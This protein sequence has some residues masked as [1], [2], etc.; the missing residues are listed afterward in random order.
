M[1][2]PETAPKLISEVFPKTEAKSELGLA[3]GS[4]QR[5]ASSNEFVRPWKIKDVVS[6]IS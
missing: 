5:L 4:E 2:T 3:F 6:S 1:S